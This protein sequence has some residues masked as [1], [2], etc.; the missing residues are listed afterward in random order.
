[1]GVMKQL[2]RDPIRVCWPETGSHFPPLAAGAT[3]MA[4]QG[5]KAALK[6]QRTGDNRVFVPRDE[7]SRSPELGRA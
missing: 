4:Q 2:R 3:G 1:M 5:Y 7:Q 6:K